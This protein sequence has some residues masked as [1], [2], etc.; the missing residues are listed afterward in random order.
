[1]VTDALE[2][3]IDDCWRVVS[4]FLAFVVEILLIIAYPF[5]AEKLAVRNGDF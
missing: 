1:M 2:G 3:S 4:H 5:K